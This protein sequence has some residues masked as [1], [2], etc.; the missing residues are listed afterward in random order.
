MAKVKL[1]FIDESDDEDFI[2]LEECEGSILF[3]SECAGYR[4]IIILDTSTA[5][6]LHKTLRTEINKA[7]EVQNETN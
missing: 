6:K 5:I 2:M 1:K 4:T 7:K 3:T